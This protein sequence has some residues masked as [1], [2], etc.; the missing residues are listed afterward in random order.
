MIL[1]RS[2]E[3]LPF[4]ITH[5]TITTT[6][7]SFA[8]V[9]CVLRGFDPTSDRL[10]DSRGTNNAHQT[11]NHGVARRAR[12][13][14]AEC[15]ETLTELSSWIGVCKR[16]AEYVAVRVQAAFQPDRVTFR[17]SSDSRVVVPEVVVVKRGLCVVSLP[18]ES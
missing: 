11:L 9:K 18:R 16:I 10:A 5:A 4:P 12:C 14:N 13:D 3:L 15:R 7:A 17:E 8:C 2:S 1:S 6:A